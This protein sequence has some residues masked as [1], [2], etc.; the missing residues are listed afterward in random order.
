MATTKI[1]NPELFDLASLDT[2]LKLPSGT[3]AE[4][5]TSPS[6][7]EWRYN[8]DNNLVE[9]WDGGAWRELQDEDLPPIPSENFNTV[10]YDGTSAN[11][12]ITGL[13]F[14]PD[15]VWIKSR[16][17][18]SWHS[19]QDSSRGATKSL[20][21]NQTNA[22]ITYTDAQTSF[23]ANGFTLGVDTQGG[24]VNVSGRNYVAWCWKANA[25]TTS[26]NTDGTITSTVQAN[27]KAGFSVV[28]YTGTGSNATVGH[29]LSAAPE[30]I[31]VKITNG[32]IGNWAIYHKDLGPT[33]V[34]QFNSGA[35][36][37]NSA[38]WNNTAPTSSVFSLGTISD[39]N[40]SSSEYIAYCFHSV[41]G[42]SKFGSYT[43]SSSNQ[44]GN[45]FVST[46]FQPAFVLIK[47]TNTSGANWLLFDNKRNSGILGEDQLNPNNNDAEKKES[48]GNPAYVIFSDDGFQ[49][50]GN[51]QSINGNGA[52]YVYAAFAAD[53]STSSPTLSDS[54]NIQVYNGDANTY[55]DITGY[56]FAPSLVWAKNRNSSNWHVWKDQL[57]STSQYSIL[58]SNLSGESIGSGANDAIS[59]FLDDGWQASSNYNGGT[60]GLTN[61]SV[62]TYV[63]WAWKANNESATRDTSGTIPAI[64]TANQAAGF[65]IVTYTGTGT[66]SQ[67]L[68]HGLG[69]KP[70]FVVI[71]QRNAISQWVG[72]TDATGTFSFFYMNTSQALTAYPS[73]SWDATYLN[74]NGGTDQNGAGDQHVAYFFRSIAGFSKIGSYTGN[75]ANQSITGL[76]F[77]PDYV[78]IKGATSADNWFVNDSLRGPSYTV[79]PNLANTETNPNQDLNLTSFDS[80]GFSVSSSP[81]VNRNGDTFMYMAFKATDQPAQ[82]I[83][84]GEMAFLGAGGGGAAGIYYGPGGGAGGLRTSYG[85]VSGRNSAP[86]S[87]ITLAAGTYTITIGA[88]GGPSQTTATS[89][90]SRS[91]VNTTIAGP[92]MTTITCNGGG[93][94]ASGGGA[95]TAFL[96]GATGGSGGG[97]WTTF[98]A[99]AGT[100]NQGY[101]GG[102]GTNLGGY[103]EVNGGGG[104]AGQA[105][106]TGTSAVGAGNGGNG[107]LN[108]ITARIAYYAGGGGAGGPE[109]G[110]GDG[111]FGVGGLG[112][113]GNGGYSTPGFENGQNAA[114][115]TGG[116]GGGGSAG[117]LAG[118]VGTN[119]LGGSGIVVLRMNTSDYSGTTTGSPSVTTDG[120]YT[121]LTYTGSG[122][123]VHS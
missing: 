44:Y 61:Q 32:S 85:T 43:G 97:G 19:L 68:P 117:I 56:G 39:T 115:N 50:N 59:E 90:S 75:G 45:V 89:P 72:F 5:P 33:K 6:T 51:P 21:S 98:G 112:G 67:T 123:Y 9:F 42:Y 12:A 70:D 108:T 41:A 14:Q 8:T 37:T 71:K 113:G 53:P 38:W 64:I 99:G 13:G 60:A 62:L 58:S 46:G 23:D 47:Q 101:Q 94:G 107:L 15:L 1:T 3:T 79:Y 11:H 30:M 91:G 40:A 100:A 102:D 27:T 10:L 24:S 65:S 17:N 86:E 36:G 22:E 81:G 20:F 25:G 28:Q 116:G 4:R 82:S 52:S 35:A 77:Q 110:A 80:D 92:S 84:A 96:T 78:M 74:L 104:G 7:G 95:G 31:I 73:M 109:S 122:T 120:D 88:G 87:N 105:G 49:V 26:S 69:A 83:A 54:F 93:G 121:I 76:G 34:L 48:G 111:T 55:K 103:S 66:N 18:A 29:G 2:A 118:S 16:S 106:E 57:R 119:G 63:G 114:P